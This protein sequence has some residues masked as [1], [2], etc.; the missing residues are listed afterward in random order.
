VVV[1]VAWVVLVL[2]SVVAAVPVVLLVDATEVVA[3]GPAP[4]VVVADWVVDAGLD[5][6]AVVGACC[7]VVP[8]DGAAAGGAVVVVVPVPHP[9][10]ITTALATISAAKPALSRLWPVVTPTLP[11][12]PAARATAGS[13]PHLYAH[14]PYSSLSQMSA[15][16]QARADSRRGLERPYTSY[17]RELHQWERSVREEP[18]SAARAGHG[19]EIS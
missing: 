18:R 9:A 4:L 11:P 1:V 2:D 10:P 6:G 3:E 7:A 19:G 16:R 5:K 13:S 14:K 17:G 15:A 8:L 12:C